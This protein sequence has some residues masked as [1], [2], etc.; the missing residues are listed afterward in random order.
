MSQHPSVSPTSFTVPCPGCGQKLRFTVAAEMPA[1]L[2]LQC[3]SC[4]KVFGVRR[5][6]APPADP[7]NSSD[8]IGINPPTLIAF[9]AS[10]R[11]GSGS[12]AGAA[13]VTSATSATSAPPFARQRRVDE[14]GFGAGEMLAGRYRLVR[15]IARGG[16]G[17]VYEAE[18]LELKERVALKTVRWD[19]ARDATAIE[20]FKREIQLARKVTH[21]N[22]CRIF[23][24][25]HHREEGAPEATIFLTMELL[26]GET[27]SQ[28]LRREGPMLPGE[29]LLIASQIAEALNAAHRVGVVHRDL[30]PGNVVLVESRSSTVGNIAGNTVGNLAGSLGAGTRAVVTDFGLARLD[31]GADPAAGQNLTLTGAAGVVGT[32]AYLAPE[33]VEGGEITAA[34][35]LF[36]F[37]I[38][39]Y[40]MI[41]GTVPFLGENALSTA[42]KRLREA[43][44]PPHVHAPG[45][46]RRWEAAILRCLE[47]DPAARFASAPEVIRALDQPVERATVMTPRLA[48]IEALRSPPP[49]SRPA[50]RGTA[51]RRLQI[52]AVAV[53]ALAAVA[54]GWM[55]FSQWREKQAALGHHLPLPATDITPRRSV[56]VLGFKDLSGQPGTAWLS[57]ALA[58]MLSTELAAGGSLRVVAGENVARA[59]VELGLAATESLA[60]DTLAKARTL[61]GS[62]AVVLGSYVALGGS[63]NAPGAAAQQIRLDVHLQGTRAGETATIVTE[64]GNEREL[65][66]L[67]S[68]VGKR[69]RRQLGVEEEDGEA[70]DGDARAALPATPEAARFYSE[71][72]ERL[73][74]FDP[75]SARDLLTRAVAAEPGNALSHSALATAWSALGYDARARDE[76]KAAFD[77]SANLPREERLLV[78]GRYREVIQDWDRAIQ[79]WWKLWSMFPDN[80]DYGLRLAA[81]QTAAGRVADALATTGAL[82]TLPAPAR[83]DPR[84]DL[85]EAMAAGAGADFKRQEAAAERA[86]TRGATQGAPLLVAQGR[87]LQCRALRNLGQG[88]AAL[89]ACEAGRKLHEQAGDR[90]GVAEALTHAA[91]VLYDRGDLPGA[92][93]LYDQALSTYREIGNRGAEAGALNNIAVVL[94]SQGDLERARQLYEQVLEISKEIGSRGG[95]AYAL[96]NLAGVLLRRGEL[97]AA[98]KLFDQSLVIRREQQDRSGIAYALDNLGV[99]LRRKGD[100]AAARKRHEEALAMRREIGQKIGEVASL[101]NLG[102]VLLDQGELPAA[103]SKFEAALRLARQTGN[104]SATAYSLFGLGEVL[105]RE[106]NA[107]EARKQH[108]EA[109]A[110]RTQLGE[111]GTS[112]E[113]QLALAGVLLDSGDTA[114]SADLARAAAEELSRQGA[115]SDQARALALTALTA[116]GRGDAAGAREA[117]GRATTLVQ[118]SQDLLS[119]L[120]V[121]LAA[122][123]LNRSEEP[124]LRG[125]AEQA[126]RAGLLDVRLQA[127]L[128]LAQR[129]A[130][131]K[132]G[133]GGDG[134]A[135]LAALQKE[136]E[137]LGYGAIARKARGG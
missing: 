79:T 85:A 70:H 3:A 74:L 96:N 54:V 28:R 92:G 31:A 46:D 87:L 112:A 8:S 60:A 83:D 75:V 39:L 38:V 77:L 119:H 48:P 114:R 30:K 35:D 126:T 49:P 123:R 34:A 101:N 86:A 52:A 137:S 64:T 117:L 133:K 21:P 11:A 127:E 84:I 36:A 45:L 16:M 14:P 105:A 62:D 73:H 37:G 78:E 24:V 130:Q 100:L 95:E 22:V 98:A 56:A 129:A 66:A 97:D 99:V 118:G 33:Q 44:V 65:F 43:P 108:E 19:V 102:T 13:S 23:D 89:A 7:A 25:S 128:A 134:G 94:K 76:A 15:F 12:L 57:S 111:K 72:M 82:R 10:D 53:L 69:L 93:R 106:G 61:L 29:A 136:A 81:V 5:P 125:I 122:A 115:A 1:R 121:E 120:T 55:R 131:G 88:D 103:R 17:E 113:S 107:A 90:A 27:L 6:G 63:P 51:R 68:R 47:R 132:N 4:G 91:N 58:E 41:T 2:R 42:V 59:K 20:R 110:L 135:R 9:P 40:E 18:D 104:K 80:V 71:G 50:P 124:V 116:S 26:P 67:V 32:P 109:L